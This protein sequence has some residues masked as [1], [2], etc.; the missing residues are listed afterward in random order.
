MDVVKCEE[1]YSKMIK[2]LNED[3]FGNDHSLTTRN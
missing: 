1:C 3:K 2:V